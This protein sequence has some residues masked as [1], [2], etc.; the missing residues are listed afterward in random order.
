MNKILKKL[1]KEMKFE[2]RLQQKMKTVEGQ[3]TNKI[4]SDFHSSVWQTKPDNQCQ[5]Q[6]QDFP[7]NMSSNQL[8]RHKLNR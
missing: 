6:V 4:I 3:K 2:A 5:D 7:Q 8:K 1:R